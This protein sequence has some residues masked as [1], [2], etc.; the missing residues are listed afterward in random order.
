MIKNSVMLLVYLLG[1]ISFGSFVAGGLG[2]MMA[3]G[4]ASY[5]AALELLR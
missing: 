2:F 1:L 4:V 5:D 3:V